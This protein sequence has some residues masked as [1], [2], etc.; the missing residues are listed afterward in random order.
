MK[1]FTRKSLIMG[2]ISGLFILSGLFSAVQ[3]KEAWMFDD[4]VEVDFVI[5]K[6]SVPMAEDVMIIDARPYKTKYVKGFIP[7]AVS[8]PFSEFDQKKDMLPKDKDTLLIYYCGGLKC[9]LSHKS[10]KKAKALG[11]TNVKV[12]AKGFPEYKKQPGAYPAITAEYVAA[13]IAK[14]ETLVVDARPKETKYDRGHI[15]TAISIPFSKFDALKGK[16]PRE[17]STPIIFYCGGLKCKLSHKSAAKAIAMGYKNVSVFTQGYP[18]WKKQFGGDAAVAVKA[19][20]I[21]GSIDLARFKE[22]LAKNP[23]SITLIDVRDKDE[24]DKGHFNTALHIPVEDLEPKIK[25]LP[26]DKP[27]VF[28]CSTGARSGEGYYMVKD[29]RPELEAYYVEATIDYKK[30]GSYTLTKN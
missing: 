8:I 22:I 25:D 7:G 16:L 15:P 2:L 11:Y 19:G 13:Q 27:V 5:S 12:F 18:V 17:L 3:A 1:A 30:D 4:I 24:F 28:V 26:S 10:A 9:K 20:E 21:E 14:N 29:V 23:G 6:I